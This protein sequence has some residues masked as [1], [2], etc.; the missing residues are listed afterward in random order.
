MSDK[1]TS[2]IKYAFF[3]TSLNFIAIPTPEGLTCLNEAADGSPVAFFNSFTS[4][5]PF[6]ASNR[7]IYPGFPLIIVIGSSPSFINILDGF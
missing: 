1:S 3:N 4:C 5:Q 2:S 7:L 6:N